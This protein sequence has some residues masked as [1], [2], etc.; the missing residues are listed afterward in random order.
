MTKQKQQNILYG[1]KTFSN[2]L[3]QNKK[4]EKSFYFLRRMSFSFES[5]SS[6]K[7]ITGEKTPSLISRLMSLSYNRMSQ[8]S[9]KIF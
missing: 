7:Y 4:I 5:S 1:I 8:N 3:I 9:L 6:Q 2:L